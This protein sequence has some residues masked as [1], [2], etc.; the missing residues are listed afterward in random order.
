MTARSDPQSPPHHNRVY[1]SPPRLV[2]PPAGH[3]PARSGFNPPRGTGRSRHRAT[4]RPPAP[5]AALLSAVLWAACCCTGCTAGRLPPDFFPIGVWYRP[6]PAADGDNADDALTLRLTND[7]ATIQ[8]LGFNT[9]F[10]RPDERLDTTLVGDVARRFQLQLAV[11]HRHAHHFLETG[12]L[13]PRYP[14][15]IWLAW[16][17]RHVDAAIVHLGHVDGPQSAKRLNDLSARHRVRR[18]APWTLATVD[19]HRPNAQPGSLSVDLRATTAAAPGDDCP[20]DSDTSRPPACNVATINTL[21][22]TPNHDDAVDEWLRCYHRA[23]AAG[24]NAALLFDPFRSNIP[25]WE[26]I[27]GPDGRVP[28][29]RASAIKRLILR[30]RKWGPRLRATT[31]RPIEFD[32]P[33]PPPVEIVLLTGPKRRYL[34]IINQSLTAF[35]RHPITVPAAFLSPERKRRA[36][37]RRLVSVPI[38]ERTVLGDVSQVHHGRVTLKTNLPPADA[39]L[40]EIF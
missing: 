26:S 12:K 10:I 37:A 22:P 24:Q 30:A 29:K 27:I 39:R 4:P 2:K 17:T 9:V 18:N 19:P 35:V 7:F 1:P 25:G 15:L 20:A 32:S 16:F 28:P 3:A 6:P 21:Q 23:L 11:P 8:G 40:Y 34:L 36:A 13:A 38:D 31:P 14:S 5:N 33:D